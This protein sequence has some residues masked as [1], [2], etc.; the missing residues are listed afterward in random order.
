MKLFTRDAYMAKECSH[1][2]YY[3]QFVTEST[4]QL[5]L[6][7]LG[8]KQ[9]I[10][11]SRQDS[12]F[13]T[14]TTGLK[15]WDSI[16]VTYD[17]E[18]WEQANGHVGHSMAEATCIKKSAARSLI[19]D[20]GH[21]IYPNGSGTLNFM[22]ED[23]HECPANIFEGEGRRKVIGLCER[24]DALLRE[25]ITE[26]DSREAQTLRDLKSVTWRKDGRI[27]SAELYSDQADPNWLQFQIVVIGTQ[28]QQ[29][30]DIVG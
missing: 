14:P 19:W 24:L 27:V 3:Q 22:S 15:V 25:G 9:L 28:H 10:Q 18:K 1:E 13:N 6:E 11:A 30:G 4:K 23:H 17:R 20:A 21:I 26:V 2:T 5:V 12:S 29:P 8:L 16:G 7:Q